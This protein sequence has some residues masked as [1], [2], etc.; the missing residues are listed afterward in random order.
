MDPLATFNIICLSIFFFGLT[1]NLRYITWNIRA[2]SVPL[3]VDLEE[4][5]IT[6]FTGMCMIY[7]RDKFYVCDPDS[8]NLLVTAFKSKAKH[9][10]HAGVVSFSCVLWKV[11]LKKSIYIYIYSEYL[12]S[13]TIPEHYIDWF[14]CRSNFTHLLVSHYEHHWL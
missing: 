12:L 9:R 4:K 13:Y 7:F 2:I 1:S 11:N 10:F 5:M 8:N 14:W 6:E 3:N